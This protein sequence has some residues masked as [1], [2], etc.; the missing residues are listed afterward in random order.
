M[1]IQ[2]IGIPFIIENDDKAKVKMFATENK[3]DFA[4]RFEIL[5]EA[6]KNGSVRNIYIH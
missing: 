4:D 1:F 6:L 3:I 2:S 5:E